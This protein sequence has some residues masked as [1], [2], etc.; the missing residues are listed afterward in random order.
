MALVNEPIG[1]SVSRGWRAWPSQ[2]PE[3]RSLTRPGL[4]NLLTIPPRVWPTMSSRLFLLMRPTRAS[5]T[6]G[7]DLT[8]PAYPLAPRICETLAPLLGE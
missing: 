5:I 1:R 6:F 8:Y 4:T 7:M 3:R 2:V